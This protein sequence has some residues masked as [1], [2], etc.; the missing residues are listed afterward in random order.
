MAINRVKTRVKEGGHIIPVETIN[1]RFENGLSNFFNIYMPLV[2][3]WIL[4]DNSD[5]KFVLIAR[6]SG[7]ELK[8]ENEITWNQLNSMY[9]G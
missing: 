3:R 7:V 2:D 8:I 4:V 1:R 9:H 5:K 6:G